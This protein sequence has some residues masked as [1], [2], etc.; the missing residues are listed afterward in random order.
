VAAVSSP[1][2]HPHDQPLCVRPAH[3][4]AACPTRQPVHATGWR[5]ALVR[6][7]AHAL[8]MRSANNTC[9]PRQVDVCDLPDI[10]SG[11]TVT[12]S[13]AEGNPLFA[14]RVLHKK[15]SFSEDGRLTVDATPVDWLVVR[16]GRALGRA[17]TPALR[18]GAW[19]PCSTPVRRR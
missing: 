18:C 6:E 14:N 17:R 15:Y 13:F 10:K 4:D 9:A 2:A 12:F 7:A 16:P 3:R 5:A 19:R 11:F 8:L 1:T